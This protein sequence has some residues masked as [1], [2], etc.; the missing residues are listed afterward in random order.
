MICLLAQIKILK[1]F[2]IRRKR[3]E[4]NQGRPAVDLNMNA[5]YANGLSASNYKPYSVAFRRFYLL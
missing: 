5:Q 4:K 1:K 3:K 2:W